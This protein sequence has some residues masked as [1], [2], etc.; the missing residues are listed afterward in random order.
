M[1]RQVKHVTGFRVQVA[2]GLVLG[3]YLSTVR[4]LRLV[5]R[6]LEVNT[7]A[8]FFELSIDEFIDAIV[9]RCFAP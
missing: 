7:A 8:T 2:R 9:A 4:S 1:A 5:Y 3:S 6:G